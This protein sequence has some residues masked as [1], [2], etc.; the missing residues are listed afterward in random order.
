MDDIVFVVNVTD[1]LNIPACYDKSC[2]LD[3]G[4]HRAITKKSVVYYYASREFRAS[5]ILPE[6]NKKEL[7]P[8]VDL[9]TPTLLKIQNGAK[10]SKL[11]PNKLKKYFE[12]F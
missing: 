10:I 5:E 9:S 3:I 2:V 1:V 6:L 7:M 8:E 4:E 11:L 12:N